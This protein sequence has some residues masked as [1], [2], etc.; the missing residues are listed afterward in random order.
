MTASVKTAIFSVAG[1]VAVSK[2][3]GFLREI[4]IA[5]RF[6][7]SADYD[8]YLIAVVLP[9]MLYG[10]LNY[11]SFYLLVPHFTRCL[12]SS[13][14]RGRD[15]W[16]T[17][18]P[19]ININLAIACA[20]AVAIVIAAP[21]VMR[22]W[23]SE[24]GAA[25]FDQIVFY[26]RALSLIVILGTSEAFLRAYLN[27][28]R[29]FVYPALSYTIY[30]VFAIGC[31]VLLYDKYGIGAIA[32][33]MVGGLT[34]Q[35]LFLAA[36]L[37]P[38]DPFRHFTA[39]LVTSSTRGLLAAGGMLVLIEA[40]NRSYFL[41]DRYFAPGFGEG[42][43]S[44]LAYGQVLVT[45]PDAIVGF[46]LGSV[47]YPLFSRNTPGKPDERFMALYEKT[48]IAAVMMAV[49]L[50]ALYF[51][52]AREIVYLVFQRG[53][54]DEHSV[55]M[56]TAVLQPLVPT[57]LSLFIISTSV[58]AGY[59]QGWRQP[60][61]LFTIGLLAVK[62]VATA[63]LSRW[64]G[65]PGIAA[66]TSVSQVGFAIAMVALIMKHR[67]KSY[68]SRLWS[69]MGRLILAGGVATGA[70]ILM[71][72]ML[73]SLAQPLTRLSA[74]LEIA[75]SWAALLAIYVVLVW[76]FGL[77]KPLRETLPMISRSSDPPI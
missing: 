71:D 6:G 16:R 60:V 19:I 50:A 46:A 15:H 3:L 21:S 35:N 53:V 27:T 57:M 70:V 74:A 31:I 14:D 49:P 5:D 25:Q 51:A 52:N 26:A 28:R 47:L 38:F 61:L 48:I 41:I 39:K 42:V 65:Y 32:I 1:V 40:V 56:T 54:F 67:P 45:L 23:A 77:R 55:Q 30:N 73:G 8:L 69:T 44:A 24:Y 4:V 33:G 68:S 13:P 11:A 10:V 20:A 18:W 63:V 34:I 76:M 59:A 72:R 37:L 2:L 17:V 22:I 62:F 66:A 7:T 75:V 12:E 64:L 9:A 58:R 29:I 36:R 43:V